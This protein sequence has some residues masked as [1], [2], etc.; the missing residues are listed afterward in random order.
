MEL[1]TKMNKACSCD[2]SSRLR[3][4][5]K[6]YPQLRSPGTRNF[7]LSM[8]GASVPAVF[9]TMTYEYRI[10][11]ICDKKTRYD[12]LCH[13]IVVF[14][15]NCTAYRYAV[16]ESMPNFGRLLKSLFCDA[17]KALPSKVDDLKS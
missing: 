2:M 14:G 12:G 9:S 3:T 11:Q 13:T 6:N 15:C 7:F 4:T 5:Y 8:S 1:P 17:D 10:E 16:W